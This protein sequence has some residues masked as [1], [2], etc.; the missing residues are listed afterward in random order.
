MT[1]SFSRLPWTWTARCSHGT[2]SSIASVSAHA[3]PFVTFTAE[4]HEKDSLRFVVFVVS[5]FESIPVL[6]R[7]VFHHP[8]NPK[9]P[10]LRGDGA[11]YVRTRKKPE[12][13][14]IA[15]QTEMRDLLDLAIEKGVRRFIERA[16]AV[17][18]W[19]Q[20]QTMPATPSDAEL[21]DQQIKGIR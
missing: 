21:F 9:A 8:L 13:T 15:S 14:E 6:C 19:P 2:A 16:K 12:T 20:W 7:K 11:C 18:A 17:G 10:I 3:D 1:C 5:E 4:L